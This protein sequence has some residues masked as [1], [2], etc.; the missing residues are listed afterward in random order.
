MWMSFSFQYT[1]LSIS[2]TKW[3]KWYVLDMQNQPKTFIG[4]VQWLYLYAC[5]EALPSCSPGKNHCPSNFHILPTF[6]RPYSQ[7]PT[8]HPYSTTKQVEYCFCSVVTRS[9]QIHYSARKAINAT[10]NDN[11]PTYQT[12]QN[13]N[14]PQIIRRRYIIDTTRC[15][16]WMPGHKNVHALKLS[17][18][19]YYPISRKVPN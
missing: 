17:P 6:I 5:N 10:M 8:K 12:M 18:H 16:T 11:F 1:C 3:V 13:I 15:G 19:H 2:K 14:M 9:M 4:I 7:W